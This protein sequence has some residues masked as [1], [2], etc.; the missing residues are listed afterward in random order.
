MGFYNNLRKA[1]HTTSAVA[2]LAG[3]PIAWSVMVGTVAAGIAIEI[4]G[5]DDDTIY[6]KCPVCGIKGSSKIMVDFKT[7]ACESCRMS[8]I[9]KKCD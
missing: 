6:D 8:D 1:I 2:G 4:V 3:G 5:D 7:V 9:E